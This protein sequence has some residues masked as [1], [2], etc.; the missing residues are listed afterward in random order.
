[1][2]RLILLLPILLGAP[3]CGP[4]AAPRASTPSTPDRAIDAL[5]SLMR[6]RLEVMHDVARYKWAKKAPIEDPEREAAL[7]KDVASRAAG[8][9]LDPDFVRAFFR[10]QIEAAKLVQR[11]DFSRWETDPE[12]AGGEVPDLAGDLRP[13]IDALNRDLLA[14]LAKLS[15]RFPGGSAASLR[16]R[17][18]RLLVGDG[19][20]GKVREAAISP[21]VA[22]CK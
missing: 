15:P 7:L 22:V 8:I 18:A 2:R 14:E 3:A 12:G 4:A 5:L 1:M 6:Q 16:G 13:R 10:G 11:A 20:N 19:I 9:G 21:L 17:A